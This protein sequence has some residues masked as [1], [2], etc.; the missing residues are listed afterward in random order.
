MGEIEKRATELQDNAMRVARATIV[1]HTCILYEELMR[2][3]S[4]CLLTLER[5]AENISKSVNF[6][7]AMEVKDGGQG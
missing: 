5:A 6:L 7:R 4:P 2:K 3:K 1:Q